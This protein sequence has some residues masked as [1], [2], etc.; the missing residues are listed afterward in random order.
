MPLSIFL[1]LFYAVVFVLVAAISTYLCIICHHFHLPYVTTSKPCRWLEFY[2]N[3]ASLISQ[4]PTDIS[5]YPDF[6]FF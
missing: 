3:S 5:F 2:P 4:L 6:S 1:V